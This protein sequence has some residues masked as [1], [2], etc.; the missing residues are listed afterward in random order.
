MLAPVA[1]FVDDL[2]GVYRYDQRG[3]GGSRWRGVHTIERRVR[4]LELLL[5]AWGYDRVSAAD[6]CIGARQ[7]G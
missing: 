4:D 7:G 1:D 2:T 6:E 5:E 3:T